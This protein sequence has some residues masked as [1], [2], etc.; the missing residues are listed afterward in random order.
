MK[1]NGLTFEQ[2]QELL[3]GVYEDLKFVLK[4]GDAGQKRRAYERFIRFQVTMQDRVQEY[5][6]TTGLDFK[7]IQKMMK[8][9]K[10]WF[11][12]EC[13]KFA[14]MNKE[15]QKELDPLIEKAKEDID[16]PI[17]SKKRKSKMEKAL[18]SKG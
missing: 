1:N 6:Q 12:E 9:Q 14:K 15:Y 3:V 7:R 5:E 18:R 11:V 8:E 17:P 10:G 2:F 4:M 13:E 16:I